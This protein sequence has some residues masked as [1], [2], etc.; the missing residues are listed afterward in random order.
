MLDFLYLLL[1]TLPCCV[2]PGPGI[3]WLCPWVRARNVF[4]SS[5]TCL[6]TPACT[7]L[8]HQAHSLSHSHP[9]LTRFLN[10][11]ARNLCQQSAF[12]HP[13]LASTHASAQATT[14]GGS[15]H[16]P[17]LYACRICF[18]GTLKEGPWD[19]SSR[20]VAF[21][22]WEGEG[23]CPQPVCPEE[24]WYGYRSALASGIT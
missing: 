18:E 20:A 13:A 14:H 10:F 22:G 5:Q 1:I 2:P 17:V 3:S 8:S 11:P 6:G 21:P 16:S 24:L 15:R 9:G 7:S 12:S 19:L 4:L 23:K